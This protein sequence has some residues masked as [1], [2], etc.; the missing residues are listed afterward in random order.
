MNLTR[1]PE[2][3]RLAEYVAGTL[4]PGT[5]DAVDSHLDECPRCQSVLEQFDSRPSSPLARLLARP[6]SATPPPEEAPDLRRLMERAKSLAPLTAP[7]YVPGASLGQYTV[8][9]PVG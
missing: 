2:G 8:L 4:D 6:S 3:E 1:C 7:H 5:L 9:E